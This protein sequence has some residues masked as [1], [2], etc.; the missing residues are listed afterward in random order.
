M[1][2]KIEKLLLGLR[3]YAAKKSNYAHTAFTSA[4][5]CHQ[6]PSNSNHFIYSRIILSQKKIPFLV[7]LHNLKKEIFVLSSNNCLI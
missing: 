3:F 7:T 2:E 4:E 1:N 5:L 6:I